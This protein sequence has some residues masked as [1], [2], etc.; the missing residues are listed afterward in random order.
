M[1]LEFTKATKLA[2]FQRSGGRCECGCGLKVLGTPEYHHRIP[3]ALGGS[4]DLD[5]CEVWD[6]KHHKQQTA[7]KDVPQ[8]AKSKRIAEKR[9]GLRSK[10]PGFRRPPPGW[11]SFKRQWK[12]Q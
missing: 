10:S 3:A 7:E 12:E 1:R 8:I 11:D 2:A 9:M 5:N 4:N 6:P